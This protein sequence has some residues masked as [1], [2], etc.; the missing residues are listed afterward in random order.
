MKKSN[1][2]TETFLNECENQLV[3]LYQIIFE[4]EPFAHP[5]ERTPVDKE[6]AKLFYNR[7]LFLLWKGNRITKETFIKESFIVG[8][9]NYALN[10]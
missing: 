5:I 6:L 8:D 3:V 7:L 10:G 4:V 1:F 2:F 9:W